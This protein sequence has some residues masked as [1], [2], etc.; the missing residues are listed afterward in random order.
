MPTRRTSIL[1]AVREVATAITSSTITTVAVFLPIAFVGDITGELF[2]PFALT[3][4]IAMAASLLVA[5]TIV[6]V[7]AYW[8]LRPGKPLLDAEGNE[9]DPEAWDAPPSRLQ[10]GY[11]P[12]LRWTLRHSWVTLG[13]AVLVLVGTIAI[14]PLMKTNFLGDSGQNTFTVTQDIGA[15]PSL[16]A[17]DAAAQQVEDALLDIEGIETVQVSIG[18]SGSALR[19]A[20]SGGGS[21]ITY[22]ITTDPD[23]D[24]VQL[25][26]DV[27]A[28]VADLEDVGTITV[29]ASGGGFGSSDIE[30]DVTAPDSQ[31]LQEATDAVVAAVSD[32][33]GIG[34]VSSNLSASLPYIS[35]VGRP[36]GRRRARP[37]RGRRRRA[38]LEHHAAA[39]H[40]HASRSTTRSLT[41]YLAASQ[42]PA[43]IDELRELTVPSAT[44]PI[45]L[46]DVATVEESE[47]PTSITTEGGQ[48][49][50]DRHRDA[51]DRQPAGG[52]RRRDD[53]PRGGRPARRRPMRRSAASSRSSRTRSR[54]SASRCSRRS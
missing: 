30:I 29:A 32:A 49:T 8:F 7:L 48:R 15:A 27:Q 17:E 44:G 9:I 53:G 28:A 50:A 1:R 21:G 51:V 45:P 4:T 38:G 36:R 14:S 47:G 11:L 19:D 2:R 26:E 33:E 24:Q 25:R 10:K 41:V 42:T 18:S 3:I 37:L 16:E 40:R 34:Q 35:V 52:L 13:L 39:G 54:S 23:A 5:L 12:I 46:S 22:S 43:T 20:F 6:P 31:T